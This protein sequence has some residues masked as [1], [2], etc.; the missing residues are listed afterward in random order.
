M[1]SK[2]CNYC[3]RLT[4]DYQYVTTHAVSRREWI[5]ALAGDDLN[6]KRRLEKEFDSCPRPVMC[7]SHFKAED[8]YINSRNQK[9]L[10]GDATPIPKV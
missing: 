7:K 5:E 1:A 6:E 9:T 4:T 8:F 3:R 10:M 2:S